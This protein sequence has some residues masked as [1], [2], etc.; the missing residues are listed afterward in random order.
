[1]CVCRNK[2]SV[3]FFKCQSLEREREKEINAENEMCVCMCVISE[4]LL[5][6]YGF[7]CFFFH[8]KNR[9]TFCV[10]SFCFIE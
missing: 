8:L 10:L 3:L 4:F 7:E 1:M 9:A 2:L 5:S 6:F